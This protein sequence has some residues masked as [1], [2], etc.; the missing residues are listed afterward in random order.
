MR[1]RRPSGHTL[2]EILVAGFIMTL[3]GLAL[4]T[5][6]RSTYN[7]QYEVLGQNSANTY[8]R[9]AADELADNL[10]GAK[11]ITAATSTG[12]TF[13]DNSGNTI[14]YWRDGG[15]L[16]K[17]VTAP[18]ASP[19]AGSAIVSG[20]D[21]LNFTYWVNSSGTWSTSTSPSTP[22]NIKAIDFTVRGTM[23][24]SNRQISGSVRVRQKP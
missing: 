20:I 17:A 18:N 10:R 16:K 4:W 12:V 15:S 21:A 14:Q 6:L 22:A 9:Q 13:T 7:S 19:S 2:I 11:A 8:A 1:R 23:N 24:G 5:L 3:L